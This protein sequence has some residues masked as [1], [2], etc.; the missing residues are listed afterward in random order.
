MIAAD[1]KFRKSVNLH[2]DLKDYDRIAGYIPTRSSVSLLKQYLK[3]TAQNTTEKATV[4]IGPYGKGKTHLML[5]L[6]TILQKAD[7]GQARLLKRKIAE[8]DREAGDYIDKIDRERKPFFPVLVYS[9]G[10]EGLHTAFVRSLYMA[11]EEAGI[12]ELAP[13]SYFDEALKAVDQWKRE[14]PDTYYEYLSLLPEYGWDAAEFGK[15]IRAYREDALTVFE[16]LYPRLTSGSKFQPYPESDVLRF[17]ESV[18]RQLTEKHGYE[19]M[20]LVFDEFGKYLEGCREKGFFSDMKV[21]QDM[22]ELANASSREQFHIAL[23]AHKS[24]HEY[25]RDLTREMKNAWKGVEGRLKEYLFVMSSRNQYELIGAAIRKKGAFARQYPMEGRFRNRKET[26]RE[27]YLLPVFSA[28]FSREE[29]EEIL[30]KGCYPLAPAAAYLLASVSEKAAQNER[31]IFT[32]LANDEHGSLARFIQSYAGGCDICAGAELV[33]DYFQTLLRRSDRAELHNE[34]LKADYAL[35]KCTDEWERKAVKATAL[36][37]LAGNQEELPAN[38][39]SISLSLGLSKQQAGPAREAVARLLDRKILVWRSKGGFYDFKNRVGIDLERAVEERSRLL[40]GRF[41]V[42]SVLPEIAE[43]SFV[44]PKIYN[45]TFKMTR[46]FRYEFLETEVFLKLGNSGYLFE[47]QFSDGL[48]LALVRTDGQGKEEEIRNKIEELNDGR[49]VV[50]YPDAVFTQ[51]ERIKKLMAVR[52]LL[53]DRDFIEDNRVLRQEL[54]LYQEDLCYEINRALEQSYFPWRGG[55]A[56]LRAGGQEDRFAD[57]A[58]FN[59]YLSGICRSCY[60][61]SPKINHELLNI[62]NVAGQYLKARNKVVERMLEGWSFQDYTK[63]TSPEALIYRSA[64]LH[65]GIMGADSPLETGCEA[66]LKL[67]DA[68]IEEAAGRKAAFSKLYEKTEGRDYGVRRGVMPLFIASRFALLQDTPVIYLQDKELEISAEVLHRLNLNP[69]KYSL[70]IEK[71][72]REKEDYLKGL[73]KLF[74]L[75]QVR[76]GNRR[77]RLA[78]TT[79]AVRRWYYSLPK[80]AA[81]FRRDITAGV[82]GRDEDLMRH[83]V[84]FR[85]LAGRMELNPREFLFE[86]LPE[87]MERG[88]WKA[89][90]KEAEKVKNMLD[91]FLESVKAYAAERTRMIF[92]GTGVGS[93]TSCLKAWYEEQGGKAGAY[94]FDPAATRFMEYLKRVD[95]FDDN[96]VVSKLSKL[97]LDLYIEDWNDDSIQEYEEILRG[98][99]GKVE[100]IQDSSQEQ[101][102]NT[103]ILHSGGESLR[104]IYDPGVRDSTSLFLGNAIAE[105]L[106]EFGDTLETGQKVAVLAQAIENLLKGQE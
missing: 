25:G 61:L 93:L 26:V 65:T 57:E 73:D 47:E 33:Y 94:L 21:L 35:S 95:T 72:S 80:Y 74:G 71:S 1:G 106:E 30:G 49:I 2:L 28:L 67:I 48:L 22:C 3:N 10:G 96:A 18:N 69:E 50:L 63:A 84:S 87:A 29:F 75:E 70:Y 13:D 51:E 36:I 86:R 43:F 7:S 82:P 99:R 103:I 77:N 90:L 16:K 27:S 54:E 34:W 56:A 88:E 24:V 66:V 64:L 97:V 60:R 14:Y 37:R 45:Q 12:R 102:K 40:T 100:S 19:G 53:N 89:C 101:G 17:Y 4:L 79:E 81:S 46:F 39:T 58:E 92:G 5:A 23:I 83:A 41:R 8:A 85:K 9:A 59:R 62:R 15:A 6:L 44:L 11:L 76:A 20:F 104:K 55:C 42:C 78:M 98:I 68:F 32:F 31:T 52:G 38:D 105:A 91:S